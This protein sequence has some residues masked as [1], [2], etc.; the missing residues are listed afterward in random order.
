MAE[1]DDVIAKR[2]GSPFLTV[3]V[4]IG[5]TIAGVLGSIL[6]AVPVGI[7]GVLG[8]GDPTG[9]LWF[10]ITAAVAAEIGYLAVGYGYCRLRDRSTASTGLFDGQT[11][12]IVIGTVGALVIGIGLFSLLGV[13]DLQPRTFYTTEEIDSG[14][15]FATAAVIVLVAPPTEEYLFRGA[16]QG[17]LRDAFGP[18]GAVA[19][20]PCSSVR[21]TFRTTS[22]PR[23]QR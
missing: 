22:D 17:R 16:N 20:A 1:T 9:L 15:F 6:F 11:R 19:G 8:P 5:L 18:A 3:L 13:F 2:E 23:C 21:P 10:V 12:A 14:V 7:V 4:A